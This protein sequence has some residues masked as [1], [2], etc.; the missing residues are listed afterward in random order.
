[1]IVLSILSICFLSSCIYF[2]YAKSNAIKKL[3]NSDD[4][5]KKN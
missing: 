3:D 5:I 1:M 2:K 4:K